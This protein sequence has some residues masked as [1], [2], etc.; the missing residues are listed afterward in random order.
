MTQTTPRILPLPKQ[1]W[2]DEAREVFAYWGEPDSWEKGSATNISMVLA[3][4]PKLALAYFEFG[5]HVLVNSSLPLRPREL[6]TLRASWLL[7]GDYEW[8]YHVGYALNIGMTLEE[9]AAI[10]DG[11]EAGNWSDADRAVLRAADEFVKGSAIADATWAALGQYF[12]RQQLMDLVFTIGNYVM[13]TGALHAFGVQLEDRVDKIGYD[14]KTESGK[15]P[16]PT[17][18]PGEPG[19]T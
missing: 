6:V 1:E 2:T 16:A 8:H 5:K 9:I 19:K 18:K 12:S 10:K 14:L 15:T 7:K 11:P 17:L 4:H 13:L 3:N